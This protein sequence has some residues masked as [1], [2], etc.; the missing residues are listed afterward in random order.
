MSICA[1]SSAHRFHVSSGV[2]ALYR[3]ELNTPER[4]VS[5]LPTDQWEFPGRLGSLALGEGM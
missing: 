2:S 1:F 3:I 5:F 4:G